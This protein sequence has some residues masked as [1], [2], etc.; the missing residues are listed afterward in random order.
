M[1]LFGATL[2]RNSSIQNNNLQEIHL[3]IIQK[4]CF[5]QLCLDKKQKLL[6]ILTPKNKIYYNE[7]F[8]N[9]KTNLY[10]SYKTLNPAKS[11]KAEPIKAPK[12]NLRKITAIKQI[13]ICCLKLINLP[14]K[15]L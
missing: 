13:I 9:K 5:S 1:S 7:A 2:K 15:S 11:I 14:P 10:E 4:F 12:A 6:Y 3:Y 8:T